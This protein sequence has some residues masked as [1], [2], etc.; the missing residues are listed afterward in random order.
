MSIEITIPEQEIVIQEAKTQTVDTI[1]VHTVIDDFGCVMASWSVGD[2][3]YNMTLWD[4]N[5]TP[6]YE[7]VGVWTNEDVFA[8]IK[9]LI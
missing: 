1:K 8:R 5:T 4:C 7:S 3:S 9:E 6:T 2:K